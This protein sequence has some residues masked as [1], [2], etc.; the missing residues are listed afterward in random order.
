MAHYCCCPVTREVCKRRLRLNP[1]VYATLHAFL[2]VHPSIESKED[3]AALGLLQYGI[4]SITN[5]RRKQAGNYIGDAFDAVAQ[6]IVEGAKGH[7]KAMNTLT[8]RWSRRMH[9]TEL[10]PIRLVQWHDSL[11]R[12]Q[13]LRSR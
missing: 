2:L 5:G 6:S 13:A 1:D 4:Y 12:L 10:P 11:C 8:I 3:L 9:L 7:S